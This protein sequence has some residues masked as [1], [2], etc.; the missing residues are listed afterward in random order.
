[1]SDFET[2]CPRLKSIHVW[3]WDYL[4]TTEARSNMDWLQ[5]WTNSLKIRHRLTSAVD[6][7][8]QN[9]TWIDFSRGQIVSKSNMDW[10][11]LIHVWFWDYLSTTEVNPCLILRLFVHDWSQSMFDFETICPRLKSIHVWFWDYLNSL[12]IRHGLT[13]VVDK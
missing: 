10:L 1:M 13:S 7:L 5:P 8:S 4:F 2:I 3:F 11:Q 6:K 9:Q 12:K